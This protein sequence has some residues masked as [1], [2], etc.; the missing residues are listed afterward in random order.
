[1]DLSI[2]TLYDS[3]AD[4]YMEFFL[5]TNDDVARREIC[6]R[7]ANNPN[8]VVARHPA[9]FT[10]FQSGDW[11]VDT[12]LPMPLPQLRHIDNVLHILNQHQE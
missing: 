1:M 3:K 8:S 4:G 2:Y 12:G 6:M 5:A 10:L 11:P 7:A 9:D